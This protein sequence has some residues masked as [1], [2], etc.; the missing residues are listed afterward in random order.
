[1]A[2][3]GA[4]PPAGTA[5]LDVNPVITP[6]TARFSA[7]NLTLFLQNGPHRRF[8]GFFWT[9]SPKSIDFQPDSV[10]I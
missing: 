5:G 3:E 10:I 2:V 9:F 6:L 7:R 4:R 8:P 1:M